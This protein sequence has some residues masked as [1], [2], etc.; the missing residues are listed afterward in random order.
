MCA[1]LS[2]VAFDR[3]VERVADALTVL[4]RAAAAADPPVFVNL[5]MEEYRDPHL[6][7]AAFRLAL[8]RPDLAG[9]DAGIVLQAYLPDSHA[10][11]DELA[12][13]A[14]ARHRAGGGHTKVRIVKGANLALERVEAE[15][16]GWVPAP[17]ATK[18]EVDAST[19]S[20]WPG[21]SIRL[22]AMPSGVGL[23]SHNLFR[24][25]VG[26]APGPTDG[27]LYR[28]EVEMLE[29]M[30]P[31]Q[32][33]AVR[34][35]GVGVRLYAPV[36]TADEFDSAVAYLWCGAWMKTAPPTI[37]CATCSPTSPRDSVPSRP[38]SPRRCGG[39][40]RWTPGPAATRTGP[41]KT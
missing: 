17:F 3:S 32:A 10:A 5:D 4:F 1:R 30:A 29:G 18:T 35:R 40:T 8:S 28:L 6:T 7:L 41:W 22:G 31:G 19:S 21:P 12:A 39:R 36:V 2:S 24:R 25:G 13:W 23:A 37:T 33:E 15:V 38:A 9:L 11:L 20:C 16:Q 27:T 26:P 34:R 14:V